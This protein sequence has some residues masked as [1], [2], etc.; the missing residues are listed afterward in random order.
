M[1]SSIN[2]PKFTNGDEVRKL[3]DVNPSIRLERATP[4]PAAGQSGIN[5]RN[6]TEFKCQDFKANVLG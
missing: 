2:I 5:L 1:R 3:F 6:G 4:N